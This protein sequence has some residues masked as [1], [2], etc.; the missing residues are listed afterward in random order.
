MPGIF[1]VIAPQRGRSEAGARE[2]ARLA[3]RMGGAIGVGSDG[4]ARLVAIAELGVWAGRIGPSTDQGTPAP[5]RSS[6]RVV[7]LAGND[8]AAEV[9]V[10]GSASP[11]AAVDCGAAGVIIDPV[12]GFCSVFTDRYGKERIFVHTDGGAT[13]FASEAKAILAVAPRTRA[14]DPSGLAEMLACGC[15]L[16]ARSLFR[17][18]DVLEPGSL[19]SVEA[20]GAWRRRRYFT[21]DR[22]ENLEPMSSREFLE[23]FGDRL[24]A[25][26]NRC[27]SDGPRFG[28]S[29]TGGLDSRM[30]MASLDAPPRT[31]P[32]YTFGSMYR[33]T[34]DVRVARRVAATCGQ[35]HTVIE[36]GEEF[37][38]NVRMY[39][40]R[41]VYIS[42][43]YLG[44]SGAAELYVNQIARGLAPARMTGNWGGELMRGVRAFKYVPPNGDF[45]V[46]EMIVRMRESA[47]RFRPAS[48][49]PISAALFQQLPYQ[50]YGRHAIERSQ[51][52]MRT[53]FLADEVV[54]WLY[55][56]PA[57]VR[58]CRAAA[59]SVIARRPELLAIP[60]DL[61][62]L[63]TGPTVARHAWRKALIK[64]EYLTSHGAPDWLAA[65]SARLPRSLV[66]TRFLGVDKF[67][68]FRFWLRGRLAD[69]VRET[70]ADLERSK[71]GAVV[72]T[73]RVKEM[74]EDHVAGRANYT[75]ELDKVLTMVTAE[76][77]LL[78]PADEPAD[79]VKI[80]E[81]VV[82]C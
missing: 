79:R 50:G 52:V 47:D 31:V 67:Q 75:D 49:H 21:P 55:R 20:S 70:L 35:S 71:V 42:D 73:R 13:F 48:S 43:G 4:R 69:F 37:L 32:C 1:G 24:R 34:G 15:T 41:A 46:P 81:P 40:E 51:L 62:L 2:L 29:L 68:H 5:T 76:R 8:T 53:P 72:D 30:I 16:G 19:F 11:I 77:Q 61:G 45:V 3:E 25:A 26:V 23:G 58:A 18:I 9:A 12:A 82:R 74:V 6:S 65:L 64:A 39:S 54:E 66:E 27:V 80:P 10:V 28:V 56:A 7:L 57:D 59:E 38:T 33:D 60:T 14:F 17:E 44:L 63:G 22:L 36:L 78:K